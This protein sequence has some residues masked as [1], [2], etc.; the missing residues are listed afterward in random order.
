MHR[1]ARRW[2]SSVSDGG[3]S[4]RP[5]KRSQSQQTGRPHG[6]DILERER[7]DGAPASATNPRKL[8]ASSGSASGILVQ[9]EGTGSRAACCVDQTHT[10]AVAHPGKSVTSTA[11]LRTDRNVDWATA[12]RAARP[13]GRSAP[14]SGVVGQSAV[15]TSGGSSSSDW[16]VPGRS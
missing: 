7:R 13:G 3:R 4:E 11:A 1:Y 12:G 10:G 6:R 8:R 5:S 2:R 15:P 16:I 9:T 14:V